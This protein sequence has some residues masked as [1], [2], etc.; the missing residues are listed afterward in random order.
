MKHMNNKLRM[1]HLDRINQAR[2]C[3]QHISAVAS[4]LKSQNRE[5][6]DID[7]TID[8]GSLISGET[9]KLHD[10]IDAFERTFVKTTIK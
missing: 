3:C 1:Q 5:F 4:L 10:L 7:G 6:V 9:D 8:A 2:C